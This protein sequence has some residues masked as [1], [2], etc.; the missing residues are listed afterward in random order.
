MRKLILVGA[1]VLPLLGAGVAQ[2]QSFQNDPGP[3]EC[4]TDPTGVQ[5]TGGLTIQD[6]IGVLGLDLGSSD[7]VNPL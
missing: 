4:T 2:A 3:T 7:Q 1:I 5:C 6:L